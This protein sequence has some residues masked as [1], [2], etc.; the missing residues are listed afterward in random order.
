MK[1]L[2]NVLKTIKNH[3]DKAADIIDSFSDN[4]FKAKDRL[5]NLLDE[6]GIIDEDSQVVIF[7][8]WYGSILIEKLAPRVKSIV[9]IDMDQSVIG[10]GK[11]NFF[12]DYDN[13]DWITTDIFNDKGRRKYIEATLFINTSCEHMPPMKEWEWWH[14]TDR[15][16]FAFQSNN[17]YGIEGHTN[18]VSNMDEFEKQMP[19]SYIIDKEEIEDTRGIRFTIIGQIC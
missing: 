9:A 6:N 15:P 3:P 4:Q 17:M 18:C 5:I 2:K 11:N 14:Q 13:V 19:S 1:L 10:I 7:G 16:Y 8:C 12:P